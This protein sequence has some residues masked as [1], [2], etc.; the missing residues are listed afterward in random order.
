MTAGSKSTRDPTEFRLRDAAFSVQARLRAPLWNLVQDMPAICSCVLDRLVPFG[1][2]LDDLRI[3]NRD[4]NLGEANLGFWVLGL[5]TRCNIRLA[6]VEVH[7]RELSQVDIRQIGQLTQALLG[8]VLAGQPGAAF[9][10]YQATFRMHGVPGNLSPA[11]F[12]QQFTNSEPEGL[13][14][15]TGS[16]AT[17]HF[18]PSGGRVSCAISA[19]MSSSF[20]D[21]IYLA[22]RVVFDAG[23]LREEDLMAEAG[24]YLKA[25][26]AALGLTLPETG[27][28]E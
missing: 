11:T 23:K 6:D 12:L 16:G 21:S 15:V 20:A 26:L 3:D 8:S 5:H 1:V 17:F 27:E 9:A 2:G 28:T 18:G 14:P 25:S 10:D 24:R 22:T 4:G 19:D 7:C 13:G